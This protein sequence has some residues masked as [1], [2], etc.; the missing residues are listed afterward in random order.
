MALRAFLDLPGG[1]AVRIGT[2][3]LL[4]GRHSSCDLQLTDESASRRQALLRIVHDDSVELVVLGRRAVYVEDR[5][6]TG[7]EI[8]AGGAQLRFPGLTCRLR[9]DRV[10]ETVRIAFCLRHGRDRLPIHTTPFIVG[11]GE[12]ANVAIAAWP[13]DALRFRVAQGTLHVEAAE[14]GATLDGTP[15]DVDTSTAVASGQRIEYRGESFAIEDAELGDASTGI[16]APSLPTRVVLQALPR[17]G[18]ATFTFPD[19]ER[20]VYLPGRRFQLVS[21]LLVPPT[22]YAAGDFVPD[23]EIIPVVWSDDDE[24]GGRQDMN[25]LLMRCRKDL[26]AAGIAP[27][28]LLQRAPGGL[29]T[30]ISI[31]AGCAVH[32]ATD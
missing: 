21:A 5:A 6:C 13:V 2:G 11:G 29:A 22:P 16:A 8:V 17:G 10:E 19:G 32:T 30:R 3:G 23:H 26:I 28:A 12:R 4:V 24:V 9:V 25:V 20:A 27:A 7:A 1:M 14:A 15:I 18:R 31:A